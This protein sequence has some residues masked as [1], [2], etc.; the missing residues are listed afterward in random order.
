MRMSNQGAELG[1]AGG[2]DVDA[3]TRRA[4]GDGGQSQPTRDDGDTENR[5][6]DAGERGSRAV[7][8][9]RSSCI[10]VPD[11][12]LTTSIGREEQVNGRDARELRRRGVVHRTGRRDG[13]QR[14]RHREAVARISSTGLDTRALVDHA[15]KSVVRRSG[16]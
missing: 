3:T 9:K 2:V 7:E 12:R 13:H 14:R 16:A 8:R 11:G 15:R 4:R 10:V 1:A 5:Q 6:G